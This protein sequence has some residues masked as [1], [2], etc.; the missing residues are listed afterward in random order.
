MNRGALIVVVAAGMLAA[1][2]S[3]GVAADRD[4]R[5]ARRPAWYNSEPLIV[6]GN[7]DS[8]RIF[9]TRKGGNPLW[10]EEAYALQHSEET[11]RKLKQLGVTI[12]VIHFYKGFGLEAEKEQL[13]DARKLAALCHR[14]GIRVGVYIGSTVGYET[15]LL[16][17]PRAAEWFVPDYLGRPVVYGNQA[18]RKRVYFMHPGYVDYMKRVVRLAIEELGA[19][20]LHFDNTSLR[21]RAEVFHHP[22]AKQHFREYLRAK[23]TPEKLKK[24]LGISDVTHVEPPYAELASPVIENPL[25]QEWTDFRCRQL[26]AFY[27]EMSRFAHGLKPDILI[28]NNPHRGISG[29]NTAWVQGVDYPSL[30]RHTDV[31]WDE[32]GNE[33]GVNADG[34]VVSRIRSFKMAS[35]LDNRVFTYTGASAV[36]MAESM[37][38][39]RQT[40]GMIG[41]MMSGYEPG[42]IPDFLRTE[43]PYTWGK[44]DPEY[45][46]TQK[47]NGYIRFFREQ[48]RYYRD[49]DS[50]ADVA[51]LHSYASMAFNQGRPYDGAYLFEQALIENHIPFA[52]IFDEQLA[53]LSRYRVLVLADQEALGEEQMDQVRRFVRDGGGLVATGTTSLFTSERRRRRDFALKDLFGV[54]APL[55]LAGPGPKPDRAPALPTVRREHDRGRVVYVPDVI[56]SIQRP[57][58]EPMT[59]KYWKASKNAAALIDA[60]SWAAGSKL[61][62]ESS[63]DSR[64]V[65]EL[66]T[67]KG[68]E[69]LLLHLINYDAAKTPVLTGIDVHLRLPEGRSAERVEVLSPDRPA[70]QSI[71]HKL[72]P[73]TGAERRIQFAVPRLEVYD[74][75]VVHLN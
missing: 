55:W 47:R 48:F 29:Y 27:G 51:V 30:L 4:V 31:V 17:Q 63:A 9:R 10:Y 13:A 43:N 21:A 67:A 32:E 49:V 60:V 41:G 2:L 6:V 59:S 74:L 24:R 44:Y 5:T 16:E 53:H 12:A 11:A 36:A 65:L 61:S 39:N 14:Y 38:F 18:F 54:K 42:E 26:A 23:Y 15:L 57:P 28:D 75:V 25:L 72:L 45:G 62:V 22:L 40:L 20:L 66:T 50:V 73:P 3:A 33:P 52:V 69:A 46:E 64:T 56:P 70:S 34:A 1:G 68:E 58:S 37:V 8:A 35:T 7:W 19:D 71:P